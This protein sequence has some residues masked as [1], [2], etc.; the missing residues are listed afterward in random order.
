M[1]GK[2]VSTSA[3]FIVFGRV[4]FAAAVL[5]AFQL[6]RKKQIRPDN[7]RDALGFIGLGALMAFHWF[8]FFHSI[9]ISTVAIGILM[10]S[11]FTVF[12]I[13]LEPLYF[14][15]K[16]SAE[17]CISGMM[18]CVG[19]GII[20]GADYDTDNIAW[21]VIWGLIAGFTYAVMLLANKNYVARY[22]AVTLTFHQFFVAMIILLP[23]VLW[24]QETVLP[25]DWAYLFVHGVVC[26][27]LAFT[28]YIFSARHL[29]AQVISVVV[30][31]EN[32]YAIILAYLILGEGL[33]L[34][35]AFGG[36]L[37]LAASYMAMRTQKN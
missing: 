11:S 36:V 30:M 10:F 22:S 20:G 6:Y 13:F 31:L 12:T 15:T 3:I 9:Q 25:M 4:L 23:I 5:L 24:M 2:L 18:C 1:F 35:M 29:D 37:I 16:L 7:M 19:V 32:L 27:A 26:T 17:A 21:G 34:R 28:M 8:T 14:K 33:E